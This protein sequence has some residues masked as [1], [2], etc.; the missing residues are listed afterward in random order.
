MRSDDA[1]LRDFL[2][3]AGLVSRSQMSDVLERMARE[4]GESAAANLGAALAQAGLL[5]HDELRRATAHALGVPF[6]ELV[7]HD[8][9]E[10]AMI[11]I[12]EPLARAHN[13]FA[14]NS[15][16]QG[17]EVAA[18]DLA[19][20][21]HVGA[22]SRGQRILPRLTSQS[23]M[24][25]AL[26]HYQKHLKEKFGEMLTAGTHIT[27]ALIKHAVFSRA[28]GVHIEPSHLGTLVRYQIGHA[29]H[30]AFTLPE[31]AGKQLVAQL[32]T[33][34]KL[35]P[36]SRPQ[37]GK[38]KVEHYGDT[39]NVRVHTLPGEHGERVHLRLASSGSGARGYTLES[40]GF[41]GEELDTIERFL[42]RRRGLLLVEGPDGAGKTTLL[43]TLADLL[44]SP[45]LA[46]VRADSATTLRG[47]LR[48]DPDV[49]VLD[50]IADEASASLAQAA[51]QRGVLVIAAVNSMAPKLVGDLTIRLAL[52][53]RL[54]TK[55]FHHS[56]KLTRADAAVLE[57]YADFTRLLA[58]L[59]SE[60]VV[61]PNVAWKDVAFAQEV[62][63][64][65]CLPADGRG[66][67]K[68]GYQGRIG[69][70]QVE[71]AGTL[72]GLSLV[73]DGLFK[74]AQGLTSLSEVLAL[75]S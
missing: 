35:L 16:E 29:L 1:L 60:Y 33:F 61:A 31:Q 42:G 48:H 4:G 11:L 22:V 49:V 68:A 54:C 25:R 43:H 69:L 46:L 26:Q 58:S 32:K 36:V 38:F 66:Q 10:G 47:A 12:P 13:I 21:E 8:I 15:G 50:N 65:E 64:S 24:R 56:S 55:T 63:C 28:G 7:P 37:E 30:E 75:I 34:A 3:D 71:E 9:S 53:R 5:E 20:L 73:E 44:A 18:L 2:I 40:L 6:V 41:H 67:G 70:S 72:A 17:L 23:S 51:A 39:V 14:F 27:D 57:K 52:V 45:H 59:K 62:P 19:D 74:A